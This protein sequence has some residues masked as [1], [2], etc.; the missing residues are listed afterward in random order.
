M[1]VGNNHNVTY[2]LLIHLRRNG[3]LLISMVIR[4]IYQII[5]GRLTPLSII[6]RT[7]FAGELS[8]G[9]FCCENKYEDGLKM[10]PKLIKSFQ[11]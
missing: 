5:Q 7:K 9:C 2:I 1:C 4:H 3:L 11:I 10:F 6:N 8:E